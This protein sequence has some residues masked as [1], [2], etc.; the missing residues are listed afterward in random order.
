MTN[1]TLRVLRLPGNSIGDEGAAALARALATNR[2]L[3]SVCLAT[4][5]PN[6]WLSCAGDGRC[7]THIHALP[8][9]V[10]SVVV[11][12]LHLGGN[13]IGDAGISALV[14]ALAANDTLYYVCDG[15][16]QRCELHMHGHIMPSLAFH[17]STLANLILALILATR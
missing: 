14:G 8:S 16:A 4:G 1:R 5:A 9:R 10:T 12:Q 15:A 6:G 17:S 13:C 3:D 2:S 7:S 11:A